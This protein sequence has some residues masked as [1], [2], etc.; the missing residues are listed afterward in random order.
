MGVNMDSEPQCQHDWVHGSLTKESLAH[1]QPKICKLCLREGFSSI[2]EMRS[3]REYANLK[4]KKE[5]GGPTA[6]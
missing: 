6:K 4:A 1:G 3:P 5:E 2:V